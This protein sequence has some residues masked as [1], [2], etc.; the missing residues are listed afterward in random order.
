[1]FETMNWVIAIFA[2]LPLTMGALPQGTYNESSRGQLHYSPSNGFMNDP[3]GMFYSNGT[4]H[5]YYQY[6]PKSIIANNPQWGHATS[7]DLLHWKTHDI[8]IDSH[9]DENSIFSGS[10]VVDRNNTSGFFDD[11][12]DPEER[13][14]AFYTLD[15]PEKE[16]QNVAYSKDGGYSFEEYTANPVID[17]NSTQF[18][19]PKVIWHEE[20]NKWVMVVAHS[21]K[22]AINFYTSSDLKN[23]TYTSNFTSGLPGYQYEVPDLQHMTVEGQDDTYKWVLFISI[24]PGAPLGGSAIQYFIGEFDGEKF[25]PDDD[26][27]RM[28]DYGKDWY[29]SQT[30]SNLPKGEVIG[31]AWANNWQYTQEVP[32]YPWRGEQSLLRKMTLATVPTNSEHSTLMLKQEP[33]SNFPATVE[34]SV[35]ILNCSAE[36]I[37]GSV[38]AFEIKLNVS[39]L[40]TG[41][42]TLP[43]VFSMTVGS[44]ENDD[45]ITI[46]FVPFQTGQYMFI[47][48]GGSNTW[49]HPLF[50]DK[51]SAY[52]E[53]QDEKNPVYDFHA[54]VDRSYIEVFTRN[55]TLAFSNAFYFT[56]G[57]VANKITLTTN[58]GF[59]AKGSVRTLKSIWN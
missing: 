23:W 19:D 4:Y 52:I 18:R 28:A 30:F 33:I 5:L 40:Y 41:N 45:K 10:A 16:V 57:T 54:I 38:G 39:G 47:D 35:D 59:S 31:L 55:G 43:T 56:D 22:Y 44:T 12:T 17:I 27:V 9:S 8:A 53:P 37:G 11:S 49:Q 29:A 46:G 6:N 58:N 36:V 2:L 42:T 48:R 13:I 26:L 21:Q 51:V 20:T 14:V 15:T 7:N 25:V 1:M 34:T 24:N 50:N 3:N 32:T